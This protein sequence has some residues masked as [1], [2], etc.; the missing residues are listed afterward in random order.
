M[1]GTRMHQTL[2]YGTV[3]TDVVAICRKVTFPEPASI[4]WH[5]HLVGIWETGK[6]FMYPGYQCHLLC[7]EKDRSTGLLCPQF[8]R[9]TQ[10]SAFFA[11]GRN[12]HGRL[13]MAYVEDDGGPQQLHEINPTGLVTVTLK[14]FSCSSLQA[15]INLS[16]IK[17]S[18]WDSVNEARRE[19]FHR[20]QANEKDSPNARRPFCS[21]H[22]RAVYQAESGQTSD[23]CEAEAPTPEALWMDSRECN[24]RPWRP[25]WSNSL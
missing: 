23:Q 1:R 18:K 14:Q 4:R 21:T 12:Q 25:V 8:A 16:K 20:R 13:G 5:S 7:L 6:N 19:L 3:D 22:L 15:V 9:A 11:K 17:T 24:R 2:S 10:T